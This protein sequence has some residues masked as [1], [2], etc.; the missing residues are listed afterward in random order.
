[1]PVWEE[2]DGQVTLSTAGTNSA[3]QLFHNEEDTDNFQNAPVTIVD[4]IL[5]AN[6]GSG[7][8]W[9]IRLIVAHEIVVAGDLGVGL[10]RSSSLIWYGFYVSGGPLVFRL[11][12]KRTIHPHH[13]LWID[14]QKKRGD[15]SGILFYGL[16]ALL[17]LSH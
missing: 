4:G 7:E 11:R 17:Q 9:Q 5:T 16:Q 15:T 12:S 10:G 6:E 3:L 14:V 8:L 2:Y 1:M 13:K